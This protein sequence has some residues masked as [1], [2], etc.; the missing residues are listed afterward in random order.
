MLMP[1]SGAERCG[2]GVECGDGFSDMIERDSDGDDEGRRR[3]KR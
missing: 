2:G 1:G 3:V